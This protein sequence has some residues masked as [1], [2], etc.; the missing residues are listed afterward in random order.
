M[1]LR[2]SIE[3]QQKELLQTERRC[4]KI[5]ICDESD[6]GDMSG[7]TLPFMQTVLEKFSVVLTHNSLHLLFIMSNPQTSIP[8]S[9]RPVRTFLVLASQVQHFQ[10]Q[11]AYY[12]LLSVFFI[13]LVLFSKQVRY[14]FYPGKKSSNST[15]CT[16]ISQ[17]DITRF[18]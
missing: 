1:F 10:P 18:M 17:N 6:E 8:Q 3:R 14:R 12:C 4:F 16:R 2:M 11:I 5:K 13:D 7:T 15:G 9:L